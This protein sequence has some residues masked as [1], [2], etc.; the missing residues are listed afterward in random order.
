MGCTRCSWSQVSAGIPM[1]VAKLAPSPYPASGTNPVPLS[2][3]PW[4]PNTPPTHSPP[5]HPHPPTHPFPSHILPHCLFDDTI[6]VLHGTARS[7]PP[8]CSSLRS[9]NHHISI[10]PPPPTHTPKKTHAHSNPISSL[11]PPTFNLAFVRHLFP[12]SMCTW[13]SY[14]FKSG[15][16]FIVCFC[17]PT[18][19]T[20]PPSLGAPHE[21]TPSLFQQVVALTTLTTPRF[22]GR[23]STRWPICRTRYRRR[24]TSPMRT[25]HSSLWLVTILMRSE[26]RGTRLSTGTSGVRTFNSQASVRIECCCF[27]ANFRDQ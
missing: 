16:M 23:Q 12:W 15:A 4:A 17:F 14:Y 26:S 22:P 10:S 13:A 3:L 9:Y 19:T 8:M 27:L 18:T 5:N 1:S 2:L 6:G 11:C 21:F 24:W 20:K 7:F 25:R